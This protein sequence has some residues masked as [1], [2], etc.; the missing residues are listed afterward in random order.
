LLLVVAGRAQTLVLLLGTGVGRLINIA[1]K[2]VIERPRPSADLVHVHSHESS[3]SFP[4]GHAEGAM[5]LY[6]LIFCFAGTYLQGARI[7]LPVQAACVWIIVVTGVQRVY[8]GAHWPSDVFG[9]Y[10]LGLL[11]VAAFV[12]L[13]R[14]VI[15][16]RK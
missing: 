7:R 4:S 16:S 5:L 6:G 15:A 13:D 2:D 10:Y 11:V 12:A 9:A 8:S 3:F 1:S 14:L